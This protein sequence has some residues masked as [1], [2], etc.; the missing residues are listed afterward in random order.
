MGKFDIVFRCVNQFLFL[1]FLFLFLIGVFAVSVLSIPI[2]TEENSTVSVDVGQI[3]GANFCPGLSTADDNP[4]LTKPDSSQINLLSGIFLGCMGAAV[5][6][7]A[8]GV[9]SASR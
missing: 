6:L 1:F 8:F 4:L 9:D 2:I 5:L 7:V 3:C